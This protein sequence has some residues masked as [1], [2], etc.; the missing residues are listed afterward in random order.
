MYN[1]FDM[2]CISVYYKIRSLNSIDIEE[3]LMRT[4]RFPKGL[5]CLMMIIF[6]LSA[7]GDIALAE[8]DIKVEINGQL[9]EF[10][11]VEP[12]VLSGRTVLPARDILEALGLNL[13]WTASTKTITATKVGLAIDLTLDSN[14]AYVNGILKTL[15]VPATSIDGR[16]VLPVRF[17]AEATGSQVSWNSSTST[18]EIVTDTTSTLI[19]PNTNEKTT[20]TAVEIGKLAK[21][22]VKIYMEDI[23][24]NLFTGS[25]FYF[26][27]NKIA[28]NYHVIENAKV[29]EIE[30]DD[31]SLYREEV[32]VIGYDEELD[33]AALSIQ[34]PGV[35]LTLGDSDNVVL[36]EKIYTIGSPLGLSNTLSD[37]IVSSIRDHFIQ[38]SAPISHGSSGGAT[39]NEYG[40]VIGITSAGYTE[41]ENLGFSI[42]INIFKNLDK[43]KNLSLAAFVVES[44]KISTPV[45]LVAYQDGIDIKVQWDDNGADY[46]MLQ[47]SDDGVTWYESEVSS[48]NLNQWSWFSEYSAIYSTNNNELDFYIRISAVKNN[49]ASAYSPG[50]K[51]HYQPVIVEVEVPTGLSSYTWGIDYYLYWD[52]SGADYYK[53]YKS[54]DGITYSDEIVMSTG[55]NKYYASEDYYFTA[56]DLQEYTYIKMTAV[57]NGVESDYSEPITLYYPRYTSQFNEEKY[58]SFLEKEYNLLFFGEYALPVWNIDIR[59]NDTMAIYMTLDHTALND[60]ADLESDDFSTLLDGLDT[61]T[62]EFKFFF[63]Q[64]VV[65]VLIYYNLFDEYPSAFEE[66]GIYDNTITYN[67][68]LSQYEVLFPLFYVDTRYSG[69][70]KYLFWWE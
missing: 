42:N 15:D 10:T 58:L 17:I 37:G 54:F 53:V 34:R 2:G 28:T 23:S 41:G 43:S 32:T 21:G 51:L 14:A 49:V 25:G 50:V 69:N 4:S 3:V 66:N 35:P 19:H 52:D 33:I 60:Y 44:N 67:S 46:Y 36:G 65:F 63:N 8:S 11:D 13:S 64:D 70:D 38:I 39:F 30:F 59:D 16:T 57:K 62:D 9:L 48:T 12:L 6:F 40:E 47:T 7:F 20:L 24:G 56:A 55:E 29:I 68:D 26:D 27:T 5:F 31:G 1:W 45:N 18:V 61:I 22:V